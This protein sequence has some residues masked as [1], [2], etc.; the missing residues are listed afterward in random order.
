MEPLRRAR[1]LESLMSVMS[2][3]S[4]FLALY[5]EILSSS[6]THVPG[7]SPEVLISRRPAALLSVAG[8]ARERL[9]VARRAVMLDE[10]RIVKGIGG[11]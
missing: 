4:I 5:L 6:V 7:S 10:T 2:M 11:F 3:K 9:A 1:V 8:R